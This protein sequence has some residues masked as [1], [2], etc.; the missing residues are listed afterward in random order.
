MTMNPQ[1]AHYTLMGIETLSLR[2][3]RHVENAQ[4]VAEWL[5]KDPRV[6]IVTYAGLEVLALLPP[7]QDDLPEGRRARSSPSRSRAATRPA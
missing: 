5:E 6:E 7:R 2:M 4:I 1:G 3:H